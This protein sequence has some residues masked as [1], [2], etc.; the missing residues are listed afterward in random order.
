MQRAATSNVPDGQ[1]MIGKRS[2]AACAAELPGGSWGDIC[3]NCLARISL[4]PALLRSSVR[5]ASH[6]CADDLPAAD[7]ELAP[8]PLPRFAD[9]ELLEEIG[10]GGMGL[11]WRAR[12]CKLNRIVALKLLRS[13]GFIEP[14]QLA[15]FRSEAAAVASLQHPHIV[16]LHDFGE[17]EGQPWFSMEFIEGQ[18]LAEAIREKPMG[19]PQAAALLQSIAQ[20]IA[21]AHSRGIVHRDIKPSN[22]LL[23]RN[24]SPC[25][26]DFGLAKRLG[27]DA[28]AQPAALSHPPLALTISGQF[29]GTPNYAP[30]E[31]LAVRHGEVGPRSDVYALGAVLYEML[32][33]QPPFAAPTI[34]ATLL[35][36]IDAPP[37][38]PRQ[39]NPRVPSELETLCLKCLEKAPARRCSTAQELADELGR[40]LRGEP[41]LAQPIGVVGRLGR[42]CK[43]KPGWASAGALAIVL[44]GTWG[45]VAII[46]AL[47][48]AERKRLETALR[49]S[50][51]GVPVP[52]RN[53]TATFSQVGFPIQEAIDGKAASGGWAIYESVGTVDPAL[54]AL[55]HTRAQT[56]VFETSTDIGYP[57]GSLLTFEL[58]QNAGG[59][60]TLGRFR[61]SAT[62]DD[63]GL[64]ADGRTSG[65]D[66]IADWTVLNPRSCSAASGVA[67]EKLGDGSILVTGPALGVDT[68][69]ITAPTSLTGITGLR[70]E[71]LPYGGMLPFNGPGKHQSDG[72]FILTEFAVKVSAASTLM[73]SAPADYADGATARLVERFVDTEFPDATWELHALAQPP[74]VAAAKRQIT[75]FIEGSGTP[76]AFQRTTHPLGGSSPV[77][78]MTSILLNT[79]SI[80]RPSLQGKI[81]YVHFAMDS[82]TY[83]TE[84]NTY[85][86]N[87]APALQQNGR[88]YVANSFSRATRD[89][90]TSL[91]LPSPWKAIEMPD[92]RQNDFSLI[93]GPNEFDAAQHADFSVNGAPII[94]G[95][96]VGNTHTSTHVVS[97]EVDIDNWSVAVFSPPSAP[98]K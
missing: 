86:G 59:Q 8:A 88:L 20:A 75:G 14:A 29:L 3:P 92:L 32:T 96:A 61:L 54:P 31:Q 24:G 33:G 83:H 53:A 37:V 77:T 30:P 71:V 2:C 52:L 4:T 98:A 45:T 6:A 95:Y 47:R 80:Y 11:V 66:V 35:Q 60:Q 64:F 26:T 73:G 10:R 25:I 51:S 93:V 90:H 58:V 40:F 17:H 38:A 44:S 72:N 62:T 42:W 76:Q 15:R 50:A 87:V 34:E 28:T 9:Y 18:T 12:Q 27:D 22:I 63:R 13:P 68:Y 1:I 48:F 46:S 19:P 36:V 23:D 78:T 89:D 65:G 84:F 57:G 7:P 79:Q 21:Y 16:A 97:R 94:F 91:A 85:G 81:A 56:A 49:A 5:T 67:L 82:R 55:D 74:S 69:T 43:R 39:L 41:I 70:L